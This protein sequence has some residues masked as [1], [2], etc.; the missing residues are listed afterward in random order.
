MFSDWSSLL[1][2]TLLLA[3]IAVVLTAA[4]HDIAVR[5]VPNW[6]ALAVALF[7]LATQ[8]LNSHLLTALLAGLSVFVVA[9]LCWR[10]GWLGAGDVKLLAAA[11]MVVPPSEVASFIV[12]VSLVGAAL[13]LVY[14]G[15]S[16]ITSAPPVQ[17]PKQLIARAV[18]AER[19]RIRRA[20]PLPYAVAIA[21]GFLFITL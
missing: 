21:G 4:L 20:G 8:L 1:S 18:R 17:R 12:A 10:R 15:A 13:A 16:R 2:F 5:T 19:W 11:A 7:G 3:S 6:M 9:A 14:L